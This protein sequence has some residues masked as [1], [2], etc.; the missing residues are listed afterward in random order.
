MLLA[1]V[2]HDVF[3]LP[4]DVVEKILRAVVVYAFLVVVLRV[5]GKR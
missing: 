5:V 3:S 1:S 4:L 2:V